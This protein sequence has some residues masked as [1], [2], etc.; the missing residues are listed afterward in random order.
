MYNLTALREEF[1]VLEEVIYLDNAATTQTPVRSVEAICDFFY[2]Y[3]GNY[4][5]A[6]HR[7][8]R[9]TTIRCEES[10][11]ELATFL[12]AYPEQIIWTGNTTGAINLVSQGLPWKK[13]DEVLCTALEHHSNLLPWMALKKRGVKIGIIPQEGGYVDPDSVSDMITG[14]TRVVAVTQMTNVTGT[15]QPVDEI[16]DITHDAGA[17]IVV[18]GAQSVGHIPVDI[19]KMDYLA[20]AGHKG[21]LGPQGVGAL[22]AEDPATL[23]ESQYGGGTVASVS[24]EEVT[25]RPVPARLEPGTPNIPGI[26]GMGPAIRLVDELGAEEIADHEEALGIA[27]FDALEELGLV[28]IFS[29]RGTS[30]LSFGVQGLHPDL[31]ATRLDEMASICVRSGM[32]CAE[33]YARSFCDQGT[34]R[35]SVACYNTREEVLV[36][37]DTLREMLDAWDPDSEPDYIPEPDPWEKSKCP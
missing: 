19:T 8:A 9:E 28:D 15:I 36:L 22:Y 1:P 11:E 7:L 33:P 25:L 4:G 18:D 2:E 21:L 13:G 5:R 10:R 35:A 16:A 14:K 37:A 27:L 3:A 24:F 12:G 20:I 23:S 31:V 29:P 32:H 26:I 30:V 6:T 34:V 17:V